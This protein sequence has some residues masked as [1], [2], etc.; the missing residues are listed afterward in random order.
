M[1]ISERDYFTAPDLEREDVNIMEYLA[2]L[3]LVKVSFREGNKWSVFDGANTISTKVEDENFLQGIEDNR[4]LFGKGDR[5]KV[6][7]RVEQFEI[8]GSLRTE[9]FIT[10]VLEHTHPEFKGQGDLL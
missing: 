7:M 9:Y 5:L 1:S 2:Y 10:E 6:N 3:S 8:D 4:V